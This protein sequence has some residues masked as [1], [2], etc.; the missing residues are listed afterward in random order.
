[1]KKDLAIIAGLFLLIIFLIIF[2]GPFTSLG[3]IT[4]KKNVLEQAQK[5]PDV[6]VTIKSL[7]VKAKIADNDTLR[8][9]GLSKMDSL[10]FDQGMLFVFDK[11]G[12]NGIWMKDMRFAIDTIWLDENKMITDIV[13]EVPPERGKKDSELTIYKPSHDSKYILEINAGLVKLNNIQVR[14]QAKFEL[15]KNQ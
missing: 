7:S 5:I 12:T 8:K 1:M 6:N 10:P 11:P 13:T 2:G 14:D 9:K 4:G 3:F 15:P